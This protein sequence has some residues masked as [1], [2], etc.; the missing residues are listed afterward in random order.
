M[1]SG[2]H[3]ETQQ[4]SPVANGLGV[5]RFYADVA[6]GLHAIA[7]PLTILR[8]SVASL[9]APGL[10][11]VHLRRYLHISSQ[12]VERACDLFDCLQDLVIA[13]QVE[14]A[15][16]P[17]ELGEL[18]EAI[19]EDRKTRLEASGVKLKVVATG[20]RQWMVG[21]FARTRQALLAAVRIAIAVSSPGDSV[22]LLATSC[23]GL[24]EISVSNRLAHRRTL[25]SSE[26]LSLAL[27]EAN[28]RSQQGE[29]RSA[30]DPFR[31]SFALP[32]QD[33]DP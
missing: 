24:V 32:L 18:L 23:N 29:F 1:S 13:N 30:E 8:S 3:S 10:T 20:E 12:Q 6:E 11:P 25:N 26:H 19:A 28:I 4:E 31:M 9:A 15:R 17:F 27:A 22:E 16:A 7:Q 5:G 2:M 14:A 21:D 33:L